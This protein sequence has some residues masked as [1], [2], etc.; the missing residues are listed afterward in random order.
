MLFADNTV[1][2]YAYAE[3]L[4]MKH[5]VISSL[6][7][8]WYDYLIHLCICLYCSN[9]Q[10]NVY[11]NNNEELRPVGNPPLAGEQVSFNLMFS[12]NH[13]NNYIR[14]DHIM[15]FLWQ[16]LICRIK[17]KVLF[18]FSDGMLECDHF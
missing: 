18:H 2:L 5:L 14:L 4:I 16:Q 9:H 17:G 6:G 15:G 13:K 3:T 10:V 7:G 11:A 12:V 8:F 1:R